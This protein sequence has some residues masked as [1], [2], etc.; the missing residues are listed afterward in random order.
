[1]IL[2]SVLL[3]AA[4]LSL[5]NC[6]LSSSNC[7]APLANA[8]A[9]GPSVSPT[10]SPVAAAPIDWDG[11]NTPPEAK[12]FDP[13]VIAVQPPR[14]QARRRADTVDAISSRSTMGSGK[15]AG[16]AEQQALDQAEEERLKQKLIICRNC[17]TAQ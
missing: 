8:A 1:M 11:L 4:A 12:A 5:S 3:I 10:A 6:C 9:P 17:S 7:S 15:D 13:E 2:R 14:K 16:F